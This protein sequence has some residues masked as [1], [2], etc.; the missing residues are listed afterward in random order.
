MSDILDRL[1][2]E[3][4]DERQ[5]IAASELCRACRLD[6]ETMI[7]LA[8]LGVFAPRGAEPGSWL[9]PADAVAPLR[10]ASRLIHDLGVNASGAAL[11]LELIEAQRELERRLRVLERLIES[12]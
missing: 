8:D 4:L 7:E 2:A 9:L 11:A 10:T 6:L 5:W 12:G 1:E 3:L